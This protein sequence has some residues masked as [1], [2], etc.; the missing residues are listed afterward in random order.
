MVV[1][2]EALVRW[3]HPRLGP[4]SPDQFIPAAE[5]TGVIRALT[6]YVVRD[7][8][9][10]CRSW[11]DAGL[12][13]T[14]SVNLSAR[15]LFD[16]HLVQDI[17][18]AIAEAGVP[19][20]ALTLELTESTVMGG[21]KRSMAVLEGLQGLGVGLSVDDF[22][23]GYSSLSHLRQLPVTELKVDK[24]FVATMTSNEHDAVIVRALVDLGRSLGLHTVAEGVE[25]TEAFEMLR[26]FECEEAQ[27]YLLSR[28]LPAQ[29]FIAWLARQQVRRI[30]HGDEVVLFTR[31]RRAAS[32]DAGS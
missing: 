16:S 9:A 1:G 13:L 5:H 23:T 30:D 2:A 25:S 12:D 29:Q 14:I 32:D 11:R 26:E 6:T 17:G 19:A 20:S 4:L 18:S 21:S 3:T 27:G 8:L 24:S 28:P 7:A 31:E 22:G 15:N 10:Q